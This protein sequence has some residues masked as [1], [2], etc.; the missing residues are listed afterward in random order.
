MGLRRGLS[1]NGAAA[2]RPRKGPRRYGAL[3]PSHA[4]MGPRP[5]GRGKEVLGDLLAIAVGR[6]WGRGQTAAESPNATAGRQHAPASMGP[7]PNGRGKRDG[8]NAAVI[9]KNASMGPRPNGRGK[10][11]AEEGMPPAGS[12]VNGA[13]AKRPRKVPQGLARQLRFCGVNGAAAKRPRKGAGGVGFRTGQCLRQWGR[14]QTAAES[15]QTSSAVRAV[16]S[17]VN[18]AAAKRPRKVHGSRLHARRERCVN[19][20]A[21]KRPRKVAPALAAPA[22]APRVNGAAAKR[23]RKVDTVAP[24]DGKHQAS[25]GPRPNGRGKI[26]NAT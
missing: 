16:Q 6:Q 20:A 23:P 25:M 10:G 14:G 5:N 17:C 22:S 15:R 24:V 18:G 1:V 11:I 9:D 3:V 13:A 7:R 2:K 21:A 12:C 26:G 4:S 19:G 8:D